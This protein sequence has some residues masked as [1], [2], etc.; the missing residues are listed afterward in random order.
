M[1]FKY[2]YESVSGRGITVY[3]IGMVFSLTNPTHLHLL[4][5]TDT[6]VYIQHPAFEEGAWWGKTFGPYKN[7]DG[8]GHGTHCAGVA[9]SAP[10]GVAKSAQVVAVKVLADNG[11]GRTSDM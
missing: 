9:V 4:Y 6:G 11:S 2:K 3:V 5:P 1:N 7:A 8:N 10:Y